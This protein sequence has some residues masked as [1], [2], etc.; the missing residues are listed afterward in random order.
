MRHPDLPALC[1]HYS[2]AI[3]TLGR[4]ARLSFSTFSF[5]DSEFHL[6]SPMTNPRSVDCSI[7]RLFR[8]EA[9]AHQL[10]AGSCFSSA[11]ARETLSLV[12][13]AF[14]GKDNP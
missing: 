12:I 1:G 5:N 4:E 10:F 6:Y 13:L 14:S 8:G 11:L 7:E 2:A 9:K 3:G